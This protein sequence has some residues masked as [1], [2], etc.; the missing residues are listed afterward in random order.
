MPTQD[1]D[2]VRVHHPD[3]VLCGHIPP[4]ERHARFQ[5]ISAAYDHLRGKSDT[6]RSTLSY[7]DQ[8]HEGIR[9]RARH[10]HNRRAD[11]EDRPPEADYAA[12]IVPIIFGGIVSDFFPL[13][14][15]L[16]CLALLMDF[17]VD[18]CG[19]GV[20]IGLNSESK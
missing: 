1:I 9:R 13:D 6:S 10:T 17:P 8:L 7:D 4:T 20:W 18:I 16:V 12:D 11:F 14:M 19:C 2:L 3:S 15:C 5:A